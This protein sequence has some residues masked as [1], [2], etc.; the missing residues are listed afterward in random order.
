M[1]Q[2]IHYNSNNEEVEEKTKAR[3]WEKER[4]L[5]LIFME[6]PR[7]SM[8]EEIEVTLVVEIKVKRKWKLKEEENIFTFYLPWSLWN[9][10]NLRKSVR[11]LL[12]SFFSDVFRRFSRQFSNNPIQKFFWVF[13]IIFL[14]GKKKLLKLSEYDLKSLQNI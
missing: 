1:S 13:F 2:K 12:L 3:W 11:N 7:K 5:I 6:N 4:R 10:K 8:P 14:Y 9:E